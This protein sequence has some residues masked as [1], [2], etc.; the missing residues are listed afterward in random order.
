MAIWTHRQLAVTEC[1]RARLGGQG[2]THHG[3]SS[4]LPGRIKNLFYR[5]WEAMEESLKRNMVRF[6]FN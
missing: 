6:A 5:W 1:G 2:E 3:P 4:E